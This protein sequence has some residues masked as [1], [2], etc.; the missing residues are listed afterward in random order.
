MLMGVRT[1]TA[2][3]NKNTSH[4]IARRYGRTHVPTAAIVTPKE[5]VRNE[6]KV[7]NGKNWKEL[8]LNKRAWNDLAEKAKTHKA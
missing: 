4:E 1:V 5:N 6:V 3:G 8:A 7:M 2:P